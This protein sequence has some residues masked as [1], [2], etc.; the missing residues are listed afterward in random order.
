MRAGR[1]VRRA[2]L[3]VTAV[4]AGLVVPAA[5]AMAAYS[6]SASLTVPA[7]TQVGQTGLAG[8]A[9]VI[10]INS[11]PQDT[12]SNTIVSVRLAPS[13]GAVASAA[14]PCPTPDPGVFSIASPAV[15][16]AGTACAGVTFTP[17]APDASGVVTLSPSSTVVLAPPGG[18]AGN[19][20]CTVNFTFSVLKLPTIDVLV[21]P[22]VQTYFIFRA[23][24]EGDSS[25]VFLESG[26]SIAV[27]VAPPTRRTINDFDGDFKSDVA[28]FRPSGFWY[29]SRSGGGTTVANWGSQ[30]DIPAA[31]DYDGDGKTDLGVFRPS[32]AVWYI[33]GTGGGTT[34]LNWGADGDVPMPADYDG[35]RKDDIAV[36]RPSTGVW[37]VQRS[38]GGTTIIN[39]GSPGDV[40][41]TGD[42][43]GDGKADFAVFRPSNAVWYINRSTGGTMVLNWGADGDIPRAGDYDGDGKTDIAVYRPSTGIWYVSRSGGGT[44]IIN[45]GSPGDIPVAGD[46]DGDGK[47][48]FTVF[49]PSNAVWY[50][51]RSSGGTTLLNW[52]AAGDYPIGPPPA[53]SS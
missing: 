42:F 36:Y 7:G 12:Q 5:P 53:L 14:T 22:G 25:G 50:I 33:S 13:C 30:G 6:S 32:N 1:C 19:D 40:P 38:G 3:V 2:V 28:V 18:A 41:A 8:S 46:Y 43:D 51:N 48:D 11:T 34:I 31:A 44:T 24:V 10:N 39:W 29:V 16:A 47:T 52:G 27:T 49:R 4:A 45:W 20:R 35:D 37:Y 23:K 17:S 21:N 15:G 9:T 26:P